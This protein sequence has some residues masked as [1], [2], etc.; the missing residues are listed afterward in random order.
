MALQEFQG[1]SDHLDPM[2]LKGLKEQL[3][4]QGLLDVQES[5]ELRVLM[6]RTVTVVFV[7]LTEAMELM[8]CL[9]QGEK[10]VFLAELATQDYLE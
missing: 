10:M 3:A 8:A 1:R 6:V 7:G 4:S 9:V 5:E 2:G